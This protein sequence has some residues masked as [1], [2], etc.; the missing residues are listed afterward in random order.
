LQNDFSL[1]WVFYVTGTSRLDYHWILK[2]VLR[3]VWRVVTEC[4]MTEVVERIEYFIG[5]IVA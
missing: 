1:A 3:C 2:V 5:V 4:L